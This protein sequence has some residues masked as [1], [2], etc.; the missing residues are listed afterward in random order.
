MVLPVMPCCGLIPTTASGFGDAVDFLQPV[1]SMTIGNRHATI[2]S[3][4][5]F[6]IVQ[7]FM[8]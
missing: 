3:D 5:I 4:H 1:N 8:L 6:F 2:K 7:V